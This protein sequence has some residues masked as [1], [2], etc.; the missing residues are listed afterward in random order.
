M[1]FNHHVKK[2][3]AEHGR[4]SAASSGLSGGNVPWHLWRGGWYPERETEVV[5][6]HKEHDV[7]E[8]SNNSVT[9]YLT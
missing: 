6:Q 3:Y 7:Y 2:N 5:S 8:Q 4:S 9:A 1:F